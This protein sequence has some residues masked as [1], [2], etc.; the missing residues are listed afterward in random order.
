[1]V[2][3]KYRARVAAL[4]EEIQRLE[5]EDI[6]A[7][8]APDSSSAQ[9]PSAGPGRHSSLTMRAWQQLCMLS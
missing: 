5:A 8:T 1:M 9:Q 4:D 6:G 2:I 3:S 7:S